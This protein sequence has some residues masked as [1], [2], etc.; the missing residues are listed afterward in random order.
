MRWIF[1][2][3]FFVNLSVLAWGLVS[4]SG[5]SASSVANSHINAARGVAGVASIELL[6]ELA[7]AESQ[8]YKVPEVESAVTAIEQRKE[9]LIEKG[10][11]GSDADA[12]KAMVGGKKVCEMI[13]AFSS[14]AKAAVLIERL[15]A[16]EVT[17]EVREIDL[18]VGERYQV[19]L[20]SLP[21]KEEAFRK[22]AEL[23]A[24]GVDS[25]VIRKGK[26]ANSISLGLFRKKSFAESHLKGMQ[27][28]GLEPKIEVIEDTV[29]ELWVALGYEQAA[30][31]SA[32]TWK[33]VMD[34]I[35]NVERRQNFC[36]DVASGE[37]F[38]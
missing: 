6:S 21:N 37:N 19:Y 17:A 15:R 14:R 18:A 8:T 28:I 16:V 26:F 10:L 9:S 27:D 32:F 4:K 38:Q 2:T 29:R 31:M 30:K 23:Q 25:Y 3:L 13:G 36:F 5:Q 33:N 11:G 7:S 1:L 22:L 12:S 24:S 35:N 20:P 34:G